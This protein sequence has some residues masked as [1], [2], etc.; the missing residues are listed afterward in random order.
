MQHAASVRLAHEAGVRIAMGTD[1]PVSPHG[2]NLGELGHLVG[3]GLSAVEAWQATQ[4]RGGPH[5]ARRRAGSL[6]PGKRADL[7]VLVGEFEDLENLPSRVEQVWKDGVRV[8]G[9][10]WRE[11][12]RSFLTDASESP[13]T[14]PSASLWLPA[15]AVLVVPLLPMATGSAK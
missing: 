15:L 12:G 8:N 2:Q 9:G 1:A 4:H 13:E 10:G 7:V 5:A 6:E 11:G 14:R 3:A